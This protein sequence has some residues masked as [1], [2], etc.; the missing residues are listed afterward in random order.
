MNIPEGENVCCAS[1]LFEYDETK[2][3]NL[4]E[5]FLH[6]KDKFPMLIVIIGGHYGE[7][8]FDCY[9]NLQVLR[10]HC[11]T[12]QPRVV[13]D[14]ARLNPRHQKGYITIPED[15]L[16]KFRV[17]KGHT[18]LGN[19]Q[20]LSE[21]LEENSQ[22]PILVQMACDSRYPVRIG[23][24]KYHAND[25]GNIMIKEKYEEHFFLMNAIDTIELDMNKLT[26]MACLSEDLDATPITGFKYGSKEEFDKFCRKLSKDVAE[27]GES[28]D[29][30]QGNNDFG[31]HSFDEMR[32][33]LEISNC[34][35]GL[36]SEDQEAENFGFEDDYYEEMPPIVPSRVPVQPQITIEAG[37]PNI[38]KAKTENTKPAHKNKPP[39]RSSPK[40]QRKDKNTKSPFG[41][42]KRKHH[43]V[44]ENEDPSAN[45]PELPIE[46]T[47]T[48]ETL[49]SNIGQLPSPPKVPPHVK[50][51]AVTESDTY[52]YADIKAGY[53]TLEAANRSYQNTKIGRAT[54]KPMPVVSKVDE[55]SNYKGMEIKNRTG[56]QS[57]IDRPED[58][59]NTDNVYTEMAVEND[60]LTEQSEEPSEEYGSIGFTQSYNKGYTKLSQ[61]PVSPQT[62]S[63]QE[64]KVF[65]DIEKQRPEN[66]K[67]DEDLISVKAMS[68]NEIGE[69]LKSL[70]LEQYTEVFKENQID[71][72]ILANLS[73]EDLQNEL[74]LRKI[75]AIRLNK[76]VTAGHIPR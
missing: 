16:I 71:G 65:S 44:K 68:I 26:C 56:V 57:N 66:V 28:Y 1:D 55:D 17:V 21:L 42:F 7:T 2:T 33:L 23:T 6:H 18:K 59:Q 19:P 25:L 36:L 52:S 41:F 53:V 69:H 50:K 29:T 48:N 8:K 22:L 40:V 14:D 54:V 24:T 51:I 63:E 58:D 27:S 5:F 47:D 64:H 3:L 75:E 62:P 73:V 9:D 61:A 39:A 76:F 67:D 10:V 43:N 45:E 11:Y 46:N 20:P 37:Q 4:R 32:R 35:T 74:G 34:A 30:R 12:S 49:N 31:E 70:K 38:D 13:A 60:Q 72:L 15:T